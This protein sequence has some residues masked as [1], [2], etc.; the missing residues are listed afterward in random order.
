MHTNLEQIN[1]WIERH[2]LSTTSEFFDSF[3]NIW[4]LESLIS[5]I[6]RPSS[7]PPI[8][9]PIRTP[10]FFE[11]M[12]PKSKKKPMPSKV[13]KSLSYM[14][15]ASRNFTVKHWNLRLTPTLSSNKLIFVQV[16]WTSFQCFCSSVKLRLK[17][18]Q[19]W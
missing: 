4:H 7:S 13:H 14:F 8:K 1:I 11:E 2:S 5:L 15:V 6:F 16:G 3:I 18:W 19:F 9:K 17:P 12:D 10:I